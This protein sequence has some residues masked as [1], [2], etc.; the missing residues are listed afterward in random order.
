M[1]RHSFGEIITLDFPYSHHRSGKKRP[2]MI[3]AQDLEG[4]LIVAR[5]TSKS[6]SLPSDVFLRNWKKA[7][8]NVPSYLRL[9]KVVTIEEVDILSMVGRLSED[10]RSRALETNIAFAQ[11]HGMA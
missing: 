7:G 5:I 11:S 8:L 1:A 4:D 9:S 6:K 3:I 2:A 10:D